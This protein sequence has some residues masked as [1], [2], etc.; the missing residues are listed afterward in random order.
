MVVMH[1]ARCWPLDS[2]RRTFGGD[3]LD[4]G[5]ESLAGLTTLPS[6]SSTTLDRDNVNTT[7]RYDRRSED[8]K[9]KA[10]DLITVPMPGKLT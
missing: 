6:R 3:L 4:A 10:A 2:K 9:R 8:A 1:A 5:A 7:R